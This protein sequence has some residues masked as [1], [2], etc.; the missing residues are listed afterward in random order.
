MKIVVSFIVLV[1]LFFVF[2][3]Y[4]YYM[5]GK[6]IANCMALKD[7]SSKANVLKVMGEPSNVFDQGKSLQYHPTKPLSSCQ[8]RLEFEEINKGVLILRSKFCDDGEVYKCRS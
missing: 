4:E 5:G 2:N 6:N 7:G 1:F 3:P 8:V